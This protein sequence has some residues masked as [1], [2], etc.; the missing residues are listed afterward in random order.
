LHG[1][2]YLIDIIKVYSCGT[3]YFGRKLVSY[4]AYSTVGEL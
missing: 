2:P 3:A 1:D 4:G